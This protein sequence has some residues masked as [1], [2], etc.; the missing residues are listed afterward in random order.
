ML[1]LDVRMF[2]SGK[3]ELEGFEIR[4]WDWEECR[5][6]GKGESG[7]G[8]INSDGESGDGERV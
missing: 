8:P 3:G 6:A 5:E 4:G 7:V 1:G 2:G